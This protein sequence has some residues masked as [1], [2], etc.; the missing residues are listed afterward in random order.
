MTSKLP[1]TEG[2]TDLLQKKGVKTEG[3]TKAQASMKIREIIAK[4]R[5]KQRQM[6]KDPITEKQTYFLRG[7]GVNPDGMTKLQAMRAITNIK[8]ERNVVNA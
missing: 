2:Q 3:M 1:L 4:Q 6:S 7:R 8:K 5:K